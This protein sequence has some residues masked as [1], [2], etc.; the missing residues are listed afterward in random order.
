MLY[1]QPLYLL[2]SVCQLNFLSSAFMNDI[3]LVMV[4]QSLQSDELFSQKQI[5]NLNLT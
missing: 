4:T 2:I 1:V 3:I 5:E